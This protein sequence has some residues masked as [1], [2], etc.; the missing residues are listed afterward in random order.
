VKARAGALSVLLDRAHVIE[1]LRPAPLTP[2]PG[3]PAGVLGLAVL[4]DRPT[5]VVDL[6][7]ALG[8]PATEPAPRWLRCRG[9]ED[10][11]ALAVDEVQGFVW[12]DPDSF[13]E[14][15]SLAGAV[16]ERVDGATAAGGDLLLR[17]D[18]ARLQP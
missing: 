6:R 1:Q 3:S 18:H 12:L 13:S 17:L 9:G 11:V 4:R 5:P 16:A 15:P 10:V 2:T 8:E 7:A 14:L